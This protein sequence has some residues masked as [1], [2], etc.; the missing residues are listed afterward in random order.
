MR[1]KHGFIKEQL[2]AIDYSTIISYGGANRN[3]ISIPAE[4][5]G[6]KLKSITSDAL[7]ELNLIG[8]LKIPLT[9]TSI[10]TGA[11]SRN[12]VTYVDNGDGTLTDG[13][14]YAKSEDGSVDY[15]NIVGYAKRDT[16]NVII[17]NNVKKISDL[18]FYS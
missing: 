17:P 14:V 5:N 15:T 18:E 12:S 2:V 13:F 3:D 8:I 6:V 7:S 11:F 16:Q 9:V 1:N 10:G 4:K